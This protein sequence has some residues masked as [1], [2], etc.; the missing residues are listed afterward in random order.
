FVAVRHPQAA[1]G[2]VGG[3]LGL[4]EEGDTLGVAPQAAPGGPALIARM[5]GVSHMRNEP[6]KLHVAARSGY[7]PAVGRL[8]RPHPP[9]PRGLVRLDQL[10]ERGGW[11]WANV[12]PIARPAEPAAMRDVAALKA[13]IAAL[14]ERDQGFRSRLGSPQFEV[15]CMQALTSAEAVTGWLL[16]YLDRSEEHTSELQSLTNL[17]CR[18][19]LE[20]KKNNDTADISN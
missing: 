16:Y 18:L 13:G 7:R 3:L 11:P 1:F 19:L 4:P 5:T 6:P 17:V 10:V 15:A 9:G 14:A 12:T 2:D 20:K 8:G